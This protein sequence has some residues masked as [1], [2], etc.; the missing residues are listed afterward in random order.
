MDKLDVR[1]IEPELLEEMKKL[2]YARVKASSDDLVISVGSKKYSKNEILQS[3]SN[4]DEV[5]LEIIDMQIEFLRDMASGE[6]YAQK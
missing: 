6:F 1:D 3:I 5:G 4:G 2:A